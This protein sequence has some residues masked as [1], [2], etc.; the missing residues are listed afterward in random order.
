MT[1]V[2]CKICDQYI[3]FPKKGMDTCI[4]CREKERLN[5]LGIITEYMSCKK[6]NGTRHRLIR[7]AHGGFRISCPLCGYCTKIKDTTKDAIEAWNA[8]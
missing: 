5:N 7:Y 3:M 4:V 8:R 1:A 2:K 6:C